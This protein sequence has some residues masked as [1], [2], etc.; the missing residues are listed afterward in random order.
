[1]KLIFK[2]IYDYIETE[3]ILGNICIRFS[4]RVRGNKGKNMQYLGNGEVLQCVARG[5]LW[6]AVMGEVLEIFDHMWWYREGGGRERVGWS[7][8]RKG[9]I[10]GVKL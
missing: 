5:T 6:S 3:A 1:M 10:D 8:T 2:M 7:G 9:K 4:N